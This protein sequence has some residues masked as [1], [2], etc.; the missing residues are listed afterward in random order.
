MRQEVAAGTVAGTGNVSPIIAT[1]DSTTV[2][3]GSYVESTKATFTYISALKTFAVPANASTCVKPACLK[4]GKSALCEQNF[5][6]V[7]VGLNVK[8][9]KAAKGVFAPAQFKGNK[10]FENHAHDVCA[11]ISKVIANC[12]ENV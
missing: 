2:V 1:D 6:S 8:A 12:G 5:A 4:A 11:A 7:F 9:V 10:E 3:E